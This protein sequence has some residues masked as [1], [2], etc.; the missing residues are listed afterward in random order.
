MVPLNSLPPP[1]KA[2]SPAQLAV[3]EQDELMR[4][5]KLK[6]EA[7]SNT[8]W[9]AYW[10]REGPA[11]LVSGWAELHPDVPLQRLEAVCPMDFLCTDINTLNISPGS[12]RAEKDGVEKAI[13]PSTVPSELALAA[14]TDTITTPGPPPEGDGCI[15]MDVDA[16]VAAGAAD[17]STSLGTDPDLKTA[18]SEQQLQQGSPCVLDPPPLDSVS[19]EQ[20]LRLWSEH[21]NT[22]YWYCF[23]LFKQQ[24]PDPIVSASEPLLQNDG[25]QSAATEL[26]AGLPFS[27]EGAPQFAVTTIEE[28]GTQFADEMIEDCGQFASNSD[29]NCSPQFASQIDEDNPQF[30]RE[31]NAYNTGRTD[32]PSLT[33]KETSCIADADGRETINSN[34]GETTASQKETDLQNEEEEE[35]EEVVEEEG[36]DGTLDAELC[37]SGSSPKTRAFQ[38]SGS[39][40]SGVLQASDRPA[41][42]GGALTA[43]G[44]SSD[45]YIYNYYTEL[46]CTTCNLYI[47][48]SFLPPSS[49]SQTSHHRAAMQDA[50]LC[51]PPLV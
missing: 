11:L 35:E 19:N 26:R 7:F 17:V 33:N 38:V 36:G 12:E 41:A 10:H 39:L 8:E 42:G 4:A 22:Y 6:A 14:H 20:V 48:T 16:T 40:P 44:T 2:P 9:D 32:P 25:S 5:L 27:G 30:V 37:A 24:N 1:L 31:E 47:L 18:P 43:A 49:P 50:W 46:F 3:S 23:E 45:R 34:P 15:E 28:D 21:Y 51:H 13:S 29:A